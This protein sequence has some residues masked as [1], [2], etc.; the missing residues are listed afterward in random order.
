[1]PQLAP[2]PGNAT[3]NDTIILRATGIKKTFRMGESDVQVLKGADL[4]IHSGEF[5]AIEGRSGSAKA[6]F[7]TC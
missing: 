4:A 6:R 1:M 2:Q 7:C 5:V 3:K